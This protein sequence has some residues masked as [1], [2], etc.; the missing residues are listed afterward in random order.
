M[1]YLRQV[2]DSKQHNW[3]GSALCSWCNTAY[4]L[5]H[6]AGMQHAAAA[7]TAAAGKCIAP[8]QEQTL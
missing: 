1:M 2:Y 4:C 7:A 8:L 6:H 3:H 5:L